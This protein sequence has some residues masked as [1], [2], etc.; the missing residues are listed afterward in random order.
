MALTGLGLLAICSIRSQTLLYSEGFETNG[1]GTRYTSNAYLEPTPNCNFFARMPASPLDVCFQ[2]NFFTG[3]QGSFFWGAE[4]VMRSGSPLPAGSLTSSLINIT[5]YGSLNVSLF[6]ATANN[7]TPTNNRWETA[8]SINIQVS[9]NGG[10][11]RTVG[12]FLGTNAFGGDL[13][14]DANLNG[15]NDVGETVVSVTAFTKHTFN[16]TGTGANLRVR[17]DCDQIGGSEE[18]GFDLI[19]VRGTIIV[20]VRWAHFEAEQVGDVVQL[21]W[22]TT[23]EVNAKEFVVER[24]DGEGTYA[25]I[26]SLAAHG[27]AGD[28]Q[29]V[30]RSPLHGLA[31]YRIRQVDLDNATSFSEALAVDVAAPIHASLYPNPTRDMATIDFGG[32]TVD[33]Q[34]QLIDRMGRLVRTIPFTS[35]STVQLPTEDLAAG[36]YFVRIEPQGHKALVEKLMVRE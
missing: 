27:T 35:A 19:E 30:D 6:F 16:F 18:F 14:L 7:I 22:G 10:A 5:S 17:I 34:I 11:Y 3:F 13:V 33:G 1:E 31:Y 29:F 8:D 21:D 26:G 2:N 20:P 28:Y 15:V 9:I 25:P 32:A 4:D 12:R 36:F 24:L 23:E